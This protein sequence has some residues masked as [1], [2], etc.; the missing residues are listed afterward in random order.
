M[1]KYLF[2]VIIPVYNEQKYLEACLTSILSQSFY[3]YEIIV[4]NDGSTDNS[5]NILNDYASRDKRIRV[6][7]KQNQGPLLARVDAIN[8]ADSE[9]CIFVDSDDCLESDFFNALKNEID[10]QKHDVFIYN[11]EL[12]SSEGVIIGKADSLFIDQSIFS[13]KE[14][15]DLFKT[16][17]EAKLNSLC[18]KAIKTSLLKKDATNFTNFSDV[19]FGEDLLLSLY[20]LHQAKSIKYLDLPLYK[21]R[22]SDGSIC[23][24]FNSRKIE[25][26]LRVYNEMFKYMSKWD[27]D[28]MDL[29]SLF[30]K[31]YGNAVVNFF[32]SSLIQGAKLYEISNI[33]HEIRMS[34]FFY[35][36]YLKKILSKDLKLSMKQKILGLLLRYKQ[37]FLIYSYYKMRYIVNILTR[38]AL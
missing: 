29:H 10:A 19:F 37:Y 11:Y 14:K 5:E 24:S 20:P 31:T 28:S 12:I 4:V 36:E 35:Q 17:V 30:I 22:M 3:D 13:G 18:I 34:D 32:S 15:K 23:R 8:L 21:Y 38:R 25:S 7:H 33:I 6:L 16:I 2:S 1:G 27:N 26:I 9:Y